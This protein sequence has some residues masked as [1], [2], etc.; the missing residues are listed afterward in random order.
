M[1]EIPHMSYVNIF[2]ISNIVGMQIIL[3]SLYISSLI[4]SCVPLS[5]NKRLPKLT[6]ILGHNLRTLYSNMI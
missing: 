2:N 4:S 3:V 6:S 1:Q 5:D